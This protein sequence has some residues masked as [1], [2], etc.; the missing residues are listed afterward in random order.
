MQ[1]QISVSVFVESMNNDDIETEARGAVAS[2]L[3]LNHGRLV[4]DQIDVDD[5]FH[6]TVY[7]VVEDE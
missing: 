2:Y 6:H 1:I 5:E 7:F 4:L 3:F